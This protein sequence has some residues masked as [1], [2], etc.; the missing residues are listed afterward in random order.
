MTHVLV[1]GAG[2]QLGRELCRADWDE[3]VTVTGL[4]RADLD[5]TDA[6]AVTERLDALAPDVVVNAAAYTAVDL[7][8]SEP[9]LARLVNADAV[10]HL[11]RWVEHAD[12][13]LVHFSTDYVFDGTK[14]GWYV[15][16]DPVAPLGVYGR[17]KANGED[18]ARTATR[19]VILRTAWVY[20]ALGSNFVTTMRRLARE[21]AELG[22]VADQIGCPTATGDLATAVV[23]L[24]A[25]DRTTEASGTFHLASPTSATWHE[26]ATAILAG[27]IADG[28][29]VDPI[30]T[31]DYPTPA[32]RPQNSRLASDVMKDA[33]GIGLRPWQDALID[34]IGELDQRE[35]RDTP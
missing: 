12:A 13:R 7:A 11:A 2:G 33:H 15:E 34:V 6:D 28:L 21:R 26:F 29:R 14:D 8:E 24:L 17:T 5:I 35:A 20:G 27:P 31:A 19:H 16:T 3:G 32:A 10:G 22:I 1:T 25:Q 4:A 9:D 23:D 18:L 30:T